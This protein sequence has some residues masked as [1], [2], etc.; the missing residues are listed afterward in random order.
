MT[1]QK[2]R[3]DQLHLRSHFL[4][5]KQYKEQMNSS[6]IFKRYRLKMIVTRIENPHLGR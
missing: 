3:K 1:K 4:Q 5:E 6:K 2:K